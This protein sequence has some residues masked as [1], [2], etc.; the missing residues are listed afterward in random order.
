MRRC[1]LV[2]HL[3][4]YHDC[5]LPLPQ[6]EQLRRHLDECPECAREFES[7][8]RIARLLSELS[9][10]DP[11][12]HLMPATLQRMRVVSS[13]AVRLRRLPAAAAMSVAAAC[14]VVLL[15][16]LV[17]HSPA[18]PR[19]A[20]RPD[21]ARELAA[22]AEMLVA[23]RPAAPFASASRPQPGVRHPLV[24]AHRPT[25][26]AEGPQATTAA[27]PARDETPAAVAAAPELATAERQAAAAFNALRRELGEDDPDLLVAA[28]QNVALKY[29]G[30]AQ[31]AEALLQAGDLQRRRGLA[32]EADAIYR[33]L[34]A[35][36]H[37]GT[38]PRA[39]AHKAL[40]D[41]RAESV[42]ADDEV[43]RY[44]YQQATEALRHGFATGESTGQA[45]LVMAD[46][47]RETGDRAE[48]VADYARAA[49]Q[50]SGE[51]AVVSLAEVL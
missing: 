33:G 2:R 15:Q 17:L 42:G 39:L 8:Q 12:S 48:A 7:L 9:P 19:V 13:R 14:L 28:L 34:L 21:L 36:S 50:G 47:A 1:K 32:A 10:L 23:A 37:D 25:P 43:T 35:T 24:S 31:A 51:P 20:P 18:G 41:L 26:V 38:L 29:P 27:A 46:I 6:R 49:N 4:A 5:E 30:T 45:L 40:G 11:P 44:H 16:A 3:Q 22:P